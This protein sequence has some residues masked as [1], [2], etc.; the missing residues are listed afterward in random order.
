MNELKKILELLADNEVPFVLV[1][2]FAAV[3]HGS[4]QLTRD[5]DLCISFDLEQLKKI[6]T[7]L[8]PYHPKH[9]MT[10][11]KLPFAEH[12]KDLTGLKNLYLDTDLGVIDFLGEITGIGNYDAVKNSSIEIELKDGRKLRVL[13][14]EALII[15]KEKMGRKK[16]LLVVEDLKVIQK[17]L[18]DR[19]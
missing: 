2:G 13:S 18:K 9:R 1:G 3:V 4:P 8:L 17:K 12:P 10:S 14:I 19:M 16:D 11:E 15:A 5:L 6:R 7:V